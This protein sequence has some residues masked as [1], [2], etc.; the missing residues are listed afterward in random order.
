M[1]KTSLQGSERNTKETAK[2]MGRQ[3]NKA[4]WAGLKFGESVREVEKGVERRRVAETSS[5]VPQGPSMLK[6]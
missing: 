2:E 5:V 4:D 1:A 3:Q 6:D